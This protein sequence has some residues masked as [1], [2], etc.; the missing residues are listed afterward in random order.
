MKGS[1]YARLEIL[2][3]LRSRRYLLFSL[4]FPLILF[5]AVAGPNRHAHIDGIPFPLYYMTGMAAWG[6]MVAVVSSGARIAG[7]RQVGWTRQLRITPLKA[8]A[9]FRANADGEVKVR[10]ADSHAAD[11][12]GQ[13]SRSDRAGR[14]D[15]TRHHRSHAGEDRCRRHGQ[16]QCGIVGRRRLEESAPDDQRSD[17]V[18]EVGKVY[19]GKVVRL[20]EF[21]AFV[22]I[23]PGTDGLLH[24]SEIAE[25]RVRE[26]KDE[27]ARGRPGDGEGARRRRQSH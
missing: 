4:A 8:S 14:K 16:G 18:P 6:T 10:T 9:Y 25:H 2:R 15:D 24:I 13:D 3:T 7:E 17:R 1:Q 11:S 21:G 5:F 26:V 23:Y 19:L 12:D 22:E 20:A 27:L